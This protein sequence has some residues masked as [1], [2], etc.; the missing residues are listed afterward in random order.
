MAKTSV[1]QPIQPT[2]DMP[3]NSHCKQLWPDGCFDHLPHV[4]RH[5][6]E[7]LRRDVSAIC[8]IARLLR[9]DE[10]IADAVRDSNTPHDEPQPFTAMTREGLALAL[11]VCADDANGRLEW[12]EQH[13][14]NGR[15]V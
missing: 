7:Y 6:V 8:T 4:Y 3:R 10:D 13:D 11:G 14:V 2:T 1:T 12:I 15:D 9:A 5:H